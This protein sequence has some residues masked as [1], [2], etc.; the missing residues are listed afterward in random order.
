MQLPGQLLTVAAQIAIQ[1]L[2]TADLFLP[3]R[4]QFLTTGLFFPHTKVKIFFR[5][6]SLFSILKGLP[7]LMQHSKGLTDLSQIIE[8]QGNNPPVL[9]VD[10]FPAK[11][12]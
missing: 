7:G 12:P 11:A 8:L 3:A 5:D 1:H 4:R 6:S 10:K 9:P 2:T